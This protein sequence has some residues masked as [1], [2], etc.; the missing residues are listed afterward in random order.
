MKIITLT[1]ALLIP[2]VALAQQTREKFTAIAREADDPF[3]GVG[4]RS[5]RRVINQGAQKT[6]SGVY[7][8]YVERPVGVAYYRA[9]GEIH[10]NADRRVWEHLA[11]DE[12]EYDP[13]KIVIDDFGNQF[14]ARRQGVPWLVVPLRKQI[15]DK[16]ALLIFDFFVASTVAKMGLDLVE[17]SLFVFGAALQSPRDILHYRVDDG[18]NRLHLFFIEKCSRDRFFRELDNREIVG[19]KDVAMHVDDFRW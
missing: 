11:A 3:Y 2:T 9:K 8:V 13:R 4:N 12:R 18:R 16:L 6:R 10:R 19:I 15:N 5:L 14:A 7:V 1:L 17:I